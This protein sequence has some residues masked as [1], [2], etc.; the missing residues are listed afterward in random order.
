M[1]CIKVST[2]AEGKADVVITPFAESPNQILDA[3][4]LLELR[5]EWPLLTLTITEWSSKCSKRSPT[6]ESPV[7]EF[8][9]S[10]VWSACGAG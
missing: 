8:A 3:C 7:L 5:P 9:A 6:V 2:V 1:E 4:T 10:G